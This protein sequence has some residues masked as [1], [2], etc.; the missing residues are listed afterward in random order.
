MDQPQPQ[1]PSAKGGSG[2]GGSAGDLWKKVLDEVQSDAAARRTKAAARSAVSSRGSPGGTGVEVDLLKRILAV[3]EAKP[4][5]ITAGDVVSQVKAE[6]LPQVRLELATAPRPKDV[7]AEFAALAAAVKGLEGK[8]QLV[9]VE[10]IV[11]RVTAAVAGTT[12]AAVEAAGKLAADAESQ[13]VLAAGKAAVDAGAQARFAAEEV[14]KQVRAELAALPKAVDVSPQLQGIVEALKAMEAKAVAVA[15][16]AKTQ[17]LVESQAALAGKLDEVLATVKQRPDD[18]RDEVLLQILESVQKPQPAYH[19]RF[20]QLMDRLNGLTTAAAGNGNG[21]ATAQ[22]I[23]QLRAEVQAIPKAVD[24]APK[25]DAILEAVRA[26]PQAVDVDALVARVAAEAKAQAV[27]VEGLVA[28]VAAEAKAQAV[29]VAALRAQNELIEKLRHDVQS[30]AAASPSSLVEQ[31]RKDL[32]VRTQAWERESADLRKAVR[33]D[34][35]E[36]AAKLRDDLLTQSIAVIE[37]TKGD[38]EAKAQAAQAALVREVKVKLAAA[39]AEAQASR[40][41]Q[42]TLLREVSEALK[43]LPTAVDPSPRLEAILAAVAALPRPAAALD[44]EALAAE[45][46]AGLPVRDAGDAKAAQRQEELLGEVLA[47]LKALPG[48]DARNTA[49]ELRGQLHALSEAQRA[50]WQAMSEA[51]RKAVAEA[52]HEAIEQAQ[53]SLA[54]SQRESIAAAQQ[55]LAESQRQAQQRIERMIESLGSKLESGMA[56]AA[57][58]SELARPEVERPAA[59]APRPE[60]PAPSSASIDLDRTYSWRAQPAPRNRTPAIAMVVTATAAVGMFLVLLVNA[61]TG[62]D[63]GAPPTPSNGNGQQIAA[64]TDTGGATDGK[65]TPAKPPPVAPA[66]TV[67]DPANTSA[68]SA[69][70]KD[71]ASIFHD[72]TIKGTGTPIVDPRI[73]DE[74]KSLANPSGERPRVVYELAQAKQIVFLVHAAGSSPS[75]TT[76]ILAELKRK[77]GQVAPTQKFTVVFSEGKRFTEAPPNGLREGSDAEKAKVESWIDFNVRTSTARATN[78]LVA[79]DVALSYA[80]DLLWIVS[81]G[82]AGDGAGQV[83]SKELVDRIATL[84]PRGDTRIAATQIG[85]P[86]AGSTLKTL[87]E[88]YGGAYVVVGEGASAQR[89]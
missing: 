37:Q 7:T 32:D 86:D 19:E 77:L 66:K 39:D 79:L 72:P 73:A 47:A 89:P 74:I 71:S 48:I 53:Q 88:K 31:V 12:K 21:A 24:P 58:R 29:D 2:G 56:I 28:R 1:Q 41:T 30:V 9:D 80:P 5:G 69:G 65:T 44:V 18:G 70:A 46:R 13:A 84:N 38:A 82:V 23:D 20:D 75:A 87:A 36:H 25:L 6:L 54:E 62:R 60:S 50:Q 67:V 49:G 52:Q 68:A 10:A 83:G 59:P 40:D 85:A 81:D 43:A 3:I 11:A 27:D 14:A 26:K 33:E 78:P 34:L 61:L 4:A 42:Q 64:N 15:E 76:T 35:G 57:R 17:A 51:Q 8:T 63:N 55:A 22:L 16:S 45:V